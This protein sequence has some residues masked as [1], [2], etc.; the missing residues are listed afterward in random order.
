MKVKNEEN[1]LINKIRE[2]WEIVR[3]IMR[4]EYKGEK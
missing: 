4:N 3:E 1:I 2:D